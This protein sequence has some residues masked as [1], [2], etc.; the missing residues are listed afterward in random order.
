MPRPASSDELDLDYRYITIMQQQDAVQGN[1]LVT[2]ITVDKKQQGTADDIIR[3]AQHID[4]HNTTRAAYRAQA[5]N[6]AEMPADPDHGA[7]KGEYIVWNYF[8][9]NLYK[10][11]A[12]TVMGSKDSKMSIGYGNTGQPLGDAYY[13]STAGSLDANGPY[14][15]TKANKTTAMK[16][17]LEN[18]CGS[19]AE[20]VDDVE[21]VHAR[22]YA[23]QRS[24]P[25]DM[26]ENM[27]AITGTY[28]LGGTYLSS[29]NKTGF[30]TSIY[31]DAI[32]WDMAKTVA[33]PTT[34]EFNWANVRYQGSAMNVGGVWTDSRS[35]EYASIGL[36]AA[37]IPLDNSSRALGTRIAYVFDR[38][39]TIQNPVDYRLGDTGDTGTAPEDSKLYMKGSD[40]VLKDKTDSMQ[41]P[42]MMFIGWE[43][44]G[45][46]YSPGEKIPMGDKPITLTSYWAQQYA[47]IR[48]D[49]G[50][51]EG[52]MDYQNVGYG[53]PTQ[54]RANAFALEHYGFSG[55]EGTGSDGKRYH[56]DD[57]EVID[58][59]SMG[60]TLTINL[61]AQW[62]GIYVLSYSAS[63]GTEPAPDQV[64]AMATATVV[65]ADYHG[66]KN[67]EHLIGWSHG[68]KVYKPGSSFVMPYEDVVMS[69][70]WH[71]TEEYDDD[72]IIDILKHR[73]TAARHSADQRDYLPLIGCICAIVSVLAVDLIILYHRKKRFAGWKII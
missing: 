64:E 15:G 3:L 68:G 46:I 34:Y 55:W 49:G 60:G 35:T 42:G 40:V 63:H 41:N 29:G 11:C 39:H 7:A 67:G 2:I 33:K 10:M 26:I 8:Q 31:T 20:L 22:I 38:D 50:Q 24:A 13:A 71:V 14:Y 51:A 5:Q 6:N 69:A 57:K 17:F 36:T 28:Y 32:V 37:N 72:D 25:G 61:T 18:T 44:D 73:Q 21:F 19:V 4:G 43:Y 47:L 56:F 58:L 54:L 70:V 27:T 59:P 62:M 53:S 48:F 9:Q 30:A 65:L 16:I 45:T 23:G 12:Y 66:T 52:S 1:A